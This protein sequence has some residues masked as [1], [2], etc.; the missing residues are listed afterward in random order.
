MATDTQ[1]DFPFRKKLFPSIDW[2]LLFKFSN[3]NSCSIIGELT[4]TNKQKS[5][6]TFKITVKK[7]EFEK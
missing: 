7:I 3:L 6:W 5:T 1:N 4:K 2:K